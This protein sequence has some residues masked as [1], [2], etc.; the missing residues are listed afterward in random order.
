MSDILVARNSWSKANDA[1]GFL[2]KSLPAVGSQRPAVTTIVSLLVAITFTSVFADNTALTK[3]D[4]FRRSHQAGIRLGVWGNR[5]DLPTPLD[6]SGEDQYRADIKNANFY[7]EAFLGIR[8][9][10]QAMVEIAA[11]LV[12]RGEVT[13]RS[14]GYDYYGNISLYPVN[15]RLKL[16]PIAGLRTPFQPYIMAGGGLHIGKNNIQFSNDYLAEY[17]ERSVTDFNFVFGGGMDW[18]LSSRM[19]LDIQG[20]YL[21]MTFS[22][23]LF[24]VRDYSG[25]AVTVGVKYLLPTLK[26]KQDQKHLRRIQ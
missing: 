15:L 13:V 17:R 21:P 20:A 2:N 18:P 25:V 22:K 16:Y 8:V 23:D 14:D 4:Q 3:T 5:G 11:G 9:L 7:A 24:G 19:A 1:L 12:N 6:M 26:G 10:P